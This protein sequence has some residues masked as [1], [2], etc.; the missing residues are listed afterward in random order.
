MESSNH[1]WNGMSDESCHTLWNL[2]SA[3]GYSAREPV[4]EFAAFPVSDRRAC[5]LLFALQP[6][7]ADL[8]NSFSGVL[9]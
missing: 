3:E 6:M 9:S 7:P 4:D 1:V 8:A 2:L 5:S